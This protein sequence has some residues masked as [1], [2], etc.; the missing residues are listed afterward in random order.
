MAGYDPRLDPNVNRALALRGQTDY[1]VPSPDAPMVPLAGGFDPIAEQDAAMAAAQQQDLAMSGLGPGPDGAPAPG[2]AAYTSD[3]GMSPPPPTQPAVQVDPNRVSSGL[4]V[5]ENSLM[6]TPSD[7]SYPGEQPAAGQQEPGAYVRP[8]ARIGGGATAA[9]RNPVPSILKDTTA[10]KDEAKAGAKSHE[11]EREVAQAGVEQGTQDLA[12]TRAGTYSKVAD[13]QDRLSENLKPYDKQLADLQ[14]SHNKATERIGIEQQERSKFMRE[15]VPKDRRSTAQKVVGALAVVFSG[16]A[17]QANLVAGLNVGQNIQTNRMDAMMS[18]VQRGID[19]DLEQQQAM[20]D[21]AKTAHAAL[22]T[23]LGQLNAKF[24]G[25]VDTLSIAKAMK[26]EQAATE[27]EALKSRGLG[28]EQQPLADEAIGRLRMESESLLAGVDRERYASL[29]NEEQRLKMIRAHQLAGPKP[30]SAKEALQLQGMALANEKA[31]RELDQG[32]Q[33]FIGKDVQITDA[34][35]YGAWVASKPSAAEQEKLRAGVQGYAQLRSALSNLRALKEKYGSEGRLNPFG[36]NT[37]GEEMNQE[38]D[39]VVAALN[40]MKDG[41]VM[42]EAEYK[43]AMQQVPG[44]GDFTTGALPKLDAIEASVRGQAQS[45][46]QQIGA[47]VVTPS[48]LT[49]PLSQ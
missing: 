31:R 45:K 19:R 20:M 35:A 12:D 26:Y 43:R 37:A 42:Q 41:S 10:E 38:R 28:A 8:R 47:T 7:M 13:V 49:R 17:D 33:V 44:A 27:I 22:G 34:N 2:P 36:D 23:E 11:L 18:L 39:R 32:N 21:N 40:M 25:D 46:L 4:G 5:P 24:G 3:P 14:D 30:I 6:S 29:R 9:E 16:L 1:R 48:D 15:F